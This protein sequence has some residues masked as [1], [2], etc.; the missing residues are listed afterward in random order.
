MTDP[1][2]RDAAAYYAAGQPAEA[3]A[4]WR[5]LLADPGAVD[6]RPVA[7]AQ[8][9]HCLL[10]L[11]DVDAA[12]RAYHEA[13]AEAEAVD[14]HDG[15]AAAWSGLGFA[16][17][18]RG[19]FT[20]AGEAFE[21]VADALD[22]LGDPLG[23]AWTRTAAG[24][25]RFQG[26][27]K[28]G[29][30]AS[31]EAALTVLRDHAPPDEL[32]W[33]EA[34]LAGILV[35]SNEPQQT[36]TLLDAVAL[37]A[38]PP[39]VVAT[40]R[41]NSGLAALMLGDFARAE[42][43]LGDAAALY[44]QTGDVRAVGKAWAALSNLHRYRGDLERAIAAHERVMALEAEHGFEV[45]AAGDLMYA[46][47]EDH[48]LHLDVARAGAERT[49]EGGRLLP[50]VD[51]AATVLGALA[52]RDER[53]ARPF[54]ILTPPCPGTFGPLF[55][56]GAVAIASYLNAHGVPTVVVPLSHYVDV[57]LGDEHARSRTREVV[58]DAIA[59]LNPRAIGVS[60][61]F[62]HLYPSGRDI[63][64]AARE[65]APGVPIIIGGPHVTYWDGECLAEAPE[66]DVVVRG[67]GEWTALELL[68]ALASGADLAAVAGITWRGPDGAVHRNRLRPLG[69]VLE[70]PPVDFD[71]LPAGFL[72]RMEV[73]GVTSR[74]CTFRCRYCHEFR[75]WGG[76]VRQYPVARVVAEME[77]LGRD[78]GN[79]MAGIDDSMLSMHD[80]YFVE[81]CQALGR[82][83]WLP[84]RFGFLTRV[85]TI[86]VEGLAAMRAVGLG[87]MSVGLET[88]SDAV[89]RAMNKGV[90]L[91]DARA[92][93]TLARDAGVGVA[94]FFI[95]GHPGDNERESAATL[96][97]VDG[98]YREDLV[99]WMDVAMFT[100]YP[101]TPF[102]THP[103]K[104]GVRILTLD[105]ARWRRSH[106]PIAELT[107]YPAGA[108]YRT[109]L[110]M[111]GVMGR[112][113]S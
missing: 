11:G 26:D 64:R 24:G 5:E 81:L 85:D 23:A 47:L 34:N 46:G 108:I 105:W 36:L 14:Q 8:L 75:F 101:G 65:A 78:H 42:G 95:V 103:D 1:R 94:G 98:L 45:E 33:A 106:R 56:R 66:I 68:R 2:A 39:H 20:A 92:G 51:P 16:H 29:A 90:T 52:H 60:V 40:V 31:Y 43:D 4:L 44:E 100:P 93:L 10:A 76:A 87:S 54:L 62:S 22:A 17:Q 73:S 79:A 71:L 35:A 74:G 88:G 77:R 49:A 83:R 67:E 9:G 99:K 86:T 61:T 13:L 41:L 97:W 38:A 57:Y 109:Y 69:D 50:D 25:A 112:H 6:Q 19:A 96:E 63:T 82:S 53:G 102:F 21:R 80:A 48:A 107:D 72:A 104:H 12:E 91:A 28:R 27:D 110:R 3:A 111:L 30:R 32:A 70:L 37:D 58:Q 113:S 18:A 89:L 15:R 55:P 84:E 59:A 7:R